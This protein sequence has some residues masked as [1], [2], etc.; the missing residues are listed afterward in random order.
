MTI[1]VDGQQSRVPRQR[2]AV[3]DG[4]VMRAVELELQ[5]EFPSVPA[6][7]VKVLVECLWSHFDDAPVREFVPLLVRKQAR[8]EMLDHLGPRTDTRVTSWGAPPV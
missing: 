4:P 7:Q 5:V 1:D 2:E 8:E 3:D 6:D